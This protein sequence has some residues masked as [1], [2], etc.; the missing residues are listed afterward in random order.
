[1]K[2]FFVV[3]TIL[4]M[5]MLPNIG[6]SQVTN[7][8]AATGEQEVKLITPILQRLSDKGTYLVAIKSG[9][10]SISSGLNIEIVF[11]NKTSP[12]LSTPPANSESNLSSTEYNKSSGMVIPSVVERTL[13]VKSYDIAINSG[14]GQEIWKKTNQ[15]PQGGRGP[16]S[17]VLDKYDIGNITI[18][19]NNIVPDPSLVDTLNQKSNNS[20]QFAALNQT[21]SKL[22]T[23]SVKFQTTI[24]VI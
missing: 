11:L 3:I 17:I 15:I 22:P 4:I 19:I 10:S 20:E 1:M 12:Y 2:Y 18:S 13:P 8:S 6:Y 9:Q 16:Q 23:D 14:D 24:I 7:N 21:G 5:L